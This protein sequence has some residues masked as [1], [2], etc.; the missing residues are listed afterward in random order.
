MEIKFRFEFGFYFLNSNFSY[1]SKFLDSNFFQTFG[2]EF[3]KRL[4]SNIFQYF[5]KKFEF[6]QI[7]EFESKFRFDSNP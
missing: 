7:L 5:L 1:F 2:F 4:N 3:F 6:F